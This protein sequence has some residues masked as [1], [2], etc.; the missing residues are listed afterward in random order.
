MSLKFVLGQPSR[1]MRTDER[2]HIIKLIVFFA[3]LRTCKSV[4]CNSR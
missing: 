3:I 2:T 1:D 4:L